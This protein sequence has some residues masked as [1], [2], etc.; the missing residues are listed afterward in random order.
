MTKKILSV[1]LLLILGAVIFF[2][3]DYFKKPMDR[4]IFLMKTNMGDIKIELWNDTRPITAGNFSTLAKDGFYDG[5]KFH[6]VID[7]F[8][9]QGGDPLSKDDSNKPFWG[10]GGPG[11]KIEDELSGNNE[12]VR[13][14]LSM[15]NAGPGTG[16]SQFF[17]NLVDNNPLD[18]RHSV[19]G[20]VIEGMDVVDAIAGT[21]VDVLDGHKP[22][23]AVV[24]E[25]VTQVVE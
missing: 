9:I 24:I 2:A 14:T 10:T 20:Q 11:Y 15:A 22:F 4:E 18:S 3:F 17:I 12:N 23:R 19:F 8:V 6:R 7:G 21:E 16:G 13:G 5:I 1:I 25:S